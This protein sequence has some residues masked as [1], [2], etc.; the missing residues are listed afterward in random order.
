MRE[1]LSLSA[2][3]AV[4]RNQDEGM[5]HD[6]PEHLS[7]L[8][9][10]RTDNRAHLRIT[11]LSHQPRLPRPSGDFLRHNLIHRAEHIAA[12]PVLA[13]RQHNA[14][15]RKTA[16]A[17]LSCKEGCVDA[18]GC[19]LVKLLR[20]DQH[21]PVL[22]LSA[23]RI[24]GLDQH[25]DSLVLRIADLQEGDHAVRAEVRV[26]CRKVRVKQLV[27]TLSDHDPSKVSVS[28]RL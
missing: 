18:A 20:P 12:K 27:L 13:G 5:R 15:Q 3:G 23:G 21:R 24:R 9:V 8:R 25:E 22:E 6:L 7:H 1:I 11:A 14:L 26:H 2:L 4:S 10:S 19:V 28:I 16:L 17:F